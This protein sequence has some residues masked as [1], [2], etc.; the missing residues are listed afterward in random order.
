MVGRATV[1]DLEPVATVEAHEMRHHLGGIERHAGSADGSRDF[2][3]P[4]QQPDSQAG[5]LSLRIDTDLV[6]VKS[7]ATT[8]GPDDT[9]NPIG[10]HG[11][12]NGAALQLRGKPNKARGRELATQGAT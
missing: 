4:S 3:D 11:Y 6:D 12:I 5:A 7:V 9:D 2:L 10:F 1:D 8:F